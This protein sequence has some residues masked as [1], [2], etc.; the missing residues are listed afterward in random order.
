MAAM[1]TVGT[2][3]WLARNQRNKS[4][5]AVT[6]TAAILMVRIA[7][8]PLVRAPQLGQASRGPTNCPQLGQWLTESL[9]DVADKRGAKLVVDWRQETRYQAL[10]VVVFR[11]VLVFKVINVKLEVFFQPILVGFGDILI[12]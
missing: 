10:P 12:R 9:L 5:T 1:G 8:R 2:S 11:I 7:I 6:P 3:V 4:P